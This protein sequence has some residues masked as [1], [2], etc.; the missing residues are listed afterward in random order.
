MAAEL[1]VAGIVV[2]AAP[3]RAAAVRRAIEGV[4]GTEIRAEESGKFV[5]IVE[6]DSAVDLA[7]RVT[8]IGRLDAVLGAAPVYHH[9]EISEDLPCSPVAM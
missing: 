2:H 5:V 7:E 4:G 9:A 1:H 6:A 8:M 3:G